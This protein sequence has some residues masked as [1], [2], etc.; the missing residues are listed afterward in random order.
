[1]TSYSLILFAHVT[2]VLCM[3]AAMSLETVSLYQMRRASALSDVRRWLEPV[4]GLPLVAM[5]SILI[6]LFSGIYLAV[7]MSAFS[8]GWP[9]ATV[10]ALLVMA[11]LGALTGKRMRAIR[12]T[13][14]NAKSIDSNLLARL[15]DPFLKIS[16]W[17]RMAV[18]LGIVLLMAAKPDLWESIVVLLAAA[19]LGV[20]WSLPW[21]RSG[22]MPT[23]SVGQ[24]D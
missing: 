2:S 15:Q 9:R 4:P 8:L 7:R 6:V 22:A 21:H 24:A 3:F 23:P 1:M 10:G 11:P 5:S 19:V 17:I 13:C 18:F 12:R 20:V 14:A 16:L